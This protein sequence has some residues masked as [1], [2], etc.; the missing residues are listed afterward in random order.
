MKKI[1]FSLLAIC[2]SLATAQ[3]QTL[4]FMGVLMY[5][6]RFQGH[7]QREGIQRTCE[8]GKC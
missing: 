6:C 5:V 7:A 3:A 1:L 8:A 4:K 2:F